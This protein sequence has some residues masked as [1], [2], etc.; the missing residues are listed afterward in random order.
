[1]TRFGFGAVAVVAFLGSRGPLFWVP[2]GA[3]P[4]F[5]VWCPVCPLEVG[6]ILLLLYDS[7]SSQ[8]SGT[9]SWHWDPL[10]NVVAVTPALCRI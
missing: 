9:R 4:E 6:R 2:G 3:V 10:C 5:G 7:A 8:R 1:M